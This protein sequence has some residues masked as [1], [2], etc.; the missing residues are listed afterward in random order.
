M[1]WWWLRFSGVVESTGLGYESVKRFE[2]DPS[3][4][5]NPRRESRCR[6]EKKEGGR[7]LDPW[8][9][10]SGGSS[11]L[12][13]SV[14]LRARVLSVAGVDRSDPTPGVA[15]SRLGQGGC[16]P[17]EGPHGKLKITSLD[18]PGVFVDVA[19]IAIQTLTVTF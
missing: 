9:V 14:K 18:H 6:R 5:M 15:D 8:G 10:V 19:R 17:R 2:S 3:R 16:E 4:G 12:S 13:R 11:L 7:S 1:R